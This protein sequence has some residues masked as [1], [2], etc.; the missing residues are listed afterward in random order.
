VKIEFFQ[1]G[2]AILALDRLLIFSSGNVYYNPVNPVNPVGNYFLVKK[3]EGLDRINRIDRIY[4]TR[5]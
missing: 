4:N 1:T 5:F 2:I 3:Q